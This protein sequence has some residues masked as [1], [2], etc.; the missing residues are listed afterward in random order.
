MAI[1]EVHLFNPDIGIR[2]R[3]TRHDRLVHIVQEM[4]LTAT[5]CQEVQVLTE[6]VTSTKANRQEEITTDRL[7]ITIHQVTC[8]EV[9]DLIVVQ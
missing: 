3:R 8:Q 9:E 1:G 2:H 4:E 6:I 5:D 7:Q